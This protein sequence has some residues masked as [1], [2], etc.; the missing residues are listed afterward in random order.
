MN[1]VFL[2]YRVEFLYYEIV[3][4]Y[5]KIVQDW[6]FVTMSNEVDIKQ[7]NF[8]KIPVSNDIKGVCS[9]LVDVRKREQTEK[10]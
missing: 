5:H 8:L 2:C 9:L 1:C 3:F 7:R 4:S 10:L 6:T